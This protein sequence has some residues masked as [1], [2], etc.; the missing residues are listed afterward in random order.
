M[1]DMHS[2]PERMMF[3]ENRAQLRRDALWQ[4]NRDPRA[5]AEELNVRDRAQSRK[6]LVDLIIGENQCVAP[7][8]Q[9]IPHFSVS[10]Q[11]AKAFLEIRVQFLFSRSAHHPAAGAIPTVTG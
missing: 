9:D 6:Q 3:G 4:K 2:H 10:L 8:Q 1:I 11:I 7:A 5:D